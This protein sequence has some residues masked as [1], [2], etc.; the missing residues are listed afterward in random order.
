MGAISMPQNTPPAYNPHRITYLVLFLHH[1]PAK[2]D[3]DAIDVG[4]MF[5]LLQ[6]LQDNKE[7]IR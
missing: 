3:S 5:Q 4:M 6:S 1:R 7:W 2:V